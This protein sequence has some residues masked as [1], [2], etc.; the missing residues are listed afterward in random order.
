[1]IRRTP[2][3]T[4]INHERWLV[5]YSD[6][7]TLLFGFFVVMYSVS[8]VNE[9]KYRVLSDTLSKAFDSN[10]T[11]AATTQPPDQL[12]NLDD[13]ASQLM[14]VLDTLVSDQNV[15][16]KS[17]AVFGNESWVEIEVD[18]NL[19]FA[20]GRA[21]PYPQA[22]TIFAELA[23]VLRPYENAVAVSG[24]TDDVPLRQNA[25]FNNN[26][27]LSAARA[28][29]VVDILALNGVEPKRLSAVGFGEFQ[30]VADNTSEEGRAKNRRVVL[31]VARER[32]EVPRAAADKI[33]AESGVLANTD[34]A[35]NTELGDDANLENNIRKVNEDDEANRAKGTNAPEEPRDLPDGRVKPVKLPSGGLLF[36]SDPDLPRSNN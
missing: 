24:H 33:I 18:S 3:E 8:Q 13:V 35:T 10:A 25:R 2:I 9:N 11:S 7:I 34:V 29:A 14:S 5:S 28:A 21:E 23:D 17:V 6:F 19:L 15:A 1:M 12:A 20:S 31:R 16:D 27:E 36:S 22:K 32:A 4:K 30:P 26:W